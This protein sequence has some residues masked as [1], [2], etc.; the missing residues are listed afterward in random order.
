MTVEDSWGRIE[1][2]L[3]ANASTVRKSLRPSAKAGAL[4]KVQ[5][6]LGLSLPAAFVDSARLHDGQKENAEHGLFPIAD[7]VLGAMPS[8]RLLALAEIGREWAMMK[9]L[10]DIG[11]FAGRKS[12]PARGVR[13][14]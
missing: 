12:E 9:E 2:W 10:Q 13:D 4:D 3:A 11:E 1:A 5:A 8:C 7:D 14:D 6:K